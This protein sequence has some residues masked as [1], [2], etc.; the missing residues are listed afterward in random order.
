M[1]QFTVRIAEEEVT[2]RDGKLTGP[3][4]DLADVILGSLEDA[5]AE[6]CI[7]GIGCY[8]ANR[9]KH[10]SALAGLLE[11]GAVFV[12]GDDPPGLTV[13]KGAVP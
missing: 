10:V 5:G 7:A 2:W 3:A 11:E 13:P 8:P 6:V 1:S 12:R 4:A 9:R